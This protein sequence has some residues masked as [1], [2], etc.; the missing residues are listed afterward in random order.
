M[1]IALIG[2]VGCSDSTIDDPNGGGTGEGVNAYISVNIAMDAGTKAGADYTTDET[3]TK[4]ENRI[5][6][7]TLY[8][9]NAP[10]ETNPLNYAA[11]VTV[12]KTDLVV[13]D[14]TD[15][16]K[17][18]SHPV[19]LTK[20]KYWVL[21]VANGGATSVLTTTNGLEDNLLKTRTGALDL[22][23]S[24]PAATS[25]EKGLV[26]ASRTKNSLTN[27]YYG[28]APYVEIEITDDNTKDNPA[29]MA[30][31]MERTFAKLTITENNTTSNKNEYSVTDNAGNDDECVVEIQGYSVININN[32]GYIFRNTVKFN[33]LTPP[34]DRGFGNIYN[35][36]YDSATGD[37]NDAGDTNPYLYVWDPISSSKKMTGLVFDD[38]S[39]SYAN[40]IAGKAATGL[41]F[42]S[43]TSMN[44]G[45]KVLVGYCP[46]NTADRNSQRNGYSTGVIFKG[47]VKPIA[48]YDNNGNDVITSYNDGDDLFYSTKTN[49]FY[50]DAAAVVADAANTGFVTAPDVTKPKDLESAFLRYF[51]DGECYYTYWIKHEDDAAAKNQTMEFAVVRNNVYNMQI[52]GISK[53]GTGDII[54]DPNDPNELVDAYFQ[55]DLIIRPWVLRIN[56]IEF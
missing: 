5:E 25:A 8:F 1:A 36:T 18:T 38:L 22:L 19:K 24:V 37:R 31:A 15:G 21:A 26:M 46:E 33:P 51:K 48:V 13:T 55:V 6:E 53:L 54:I 34:L 20:G 42:T 56:N 27:K 10:G 23:T 41:T 29:Y 35:S 16:A 3:A 12:G 9:F 39:A 4:E 30:I 40:H 43:M 44:A 2:F 50:I 47:L 7:L 14:A 32:S 52:T 11:H 28:S 45:D 17:I 49:K